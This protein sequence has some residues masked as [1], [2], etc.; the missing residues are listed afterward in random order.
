MAKLAVVPLVA[1][2]QG[3]APVPTLARSSYTRRIASR[4]VPART[5]TRRRCSPAGATVENDVPV[6]PPCGP[7]TVSWARATG[8][9]R[10]GASRV[11]RVSLIMFVWSRSDRGAR[12]VDTPGGDERDGA[13]PRKVGFVAAGTP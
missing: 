3:D 4:K 5:S 6:V 8:T 9:K 13:R 1:P 10:D 12:S 7:S 11:A 2:Y